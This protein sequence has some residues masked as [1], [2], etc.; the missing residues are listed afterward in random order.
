LLFSIGFV[1]SFVVNLLQN[2]DNIEK[3]VKFCIEKNV[4]F[5][6]YVVDKYFALHVLRKAKFQR[7]RVLER[8]ELLFKDRVLKGIPKRSCKI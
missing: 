1:Y 8:T 4:Y 7:A 3:F 5:C 2:D 6:I